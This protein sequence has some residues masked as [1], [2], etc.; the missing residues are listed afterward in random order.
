M[1]SKIRVLDEITINQI[2]AGEVIE[3][4]ASVVK[5]LVENSIDAGSTEITI[6]IKGG[7]RLLIRISDNGL[8]MGK[9]DALLCLERHATSKIQ[10]VEQLHET[11]TMGFRGEALPSIAS[12]S[13]F[14]IL[15]TPRNGTQ[16]GTMVV[17]EGG[18]I[19]KASAAIREPGTTMEVKSLFYNVPVRRKFQKSPASDAADVQKIVTL[20]ALANPAI[21]F[22]FIN[23]EERVFHLEAGVQDRQEIMKAR[24]D[25]L[26]GKDYLLHS[27]WVEI[28]KSPYKIFGWIGAPHAHRQNRTGQFIFINR[29]AVSVPFIQYALKDAYGPLL[30][31]QRHPIF[32]LHVELPTD[33]VD[34]N[35]HPQ[36]KE[37]RLRKEN[38]IRELLFEAARSALKTHSIDSSVDFIIEPCFQSETPS[39]NLEN[40]VMEEPPLPRFVDGP[41]LHCEK[42]ME[43]TPQ[44]TL[45]TQME[46]KLEQ[47]AEKTIPRVLTTLHGYIVVDTMTIDWF[48]NKTGG[49]SLVDQKAAHNRI[50]FEKLSASQEN[51]IQIQQLLIPLTLGTSSQE[52]EILKPCLEL[53]QK[54][55]IDIQE[56]G[57][58]SFVIQ[59]LPSILIDLDITAL[60]F[61]LLHDLKET[62]DYKQGPQFLE[63]KIYRSLAHAASKASVSRKSKLSLEEAQT[64]LRELVQCKSPHISPTGQPTIAR[65]SEDEI[66]KQF[67]K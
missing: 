28:E 63:Q 48:S 31:S 34:V 23:N 42:I 4:P 43:S 8:G 3:N 65:F 44:E 6:E 38:E 29:R 45:L 21:S 30:P 5:E 57:G 49:L 33:T 36:K 11:L 2:A 47:L 58:N 9:D 20:L 7:G 17:V 14:T 16:D 1:T 52:A 66:E 24:V 46:I 12:I 27:H 40:F 18:K 55:G 64:L 61:D 59:A 26:L 37:V 53:L 15:T 67:R 35:V 25:H 54:Q 41:K 39:F 19:L 56:F 50:L 10:N 13:K 32:I 62:A 22:Q 60:M 51:Q